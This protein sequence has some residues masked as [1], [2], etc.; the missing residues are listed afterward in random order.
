MK[1]D[2]LEEVGEK[3][4]I[5]YNMKLSNPTMSSKKYIIFLFRIVENG[6]GVKLKNVCIENI[7]SMVIFCSDDLYFYSCVIRGMW[8]F[9]T[10]TDLYPITNIPKIN[11]SCNF[12]FENFLSDILW[13]PL[14]I[15]ILPL[16]KHK[17]IEC[18]KSQGIHASEWLQGLNENSHSYF[19]NFKHRILLLCFYF[20]TFIIYFIKLCYVFHIDLCQVTE[21]LIVST[22]NELI[23]QLKFV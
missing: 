1:R 7:I 20:N 12:I 23:T 6:L 9:T 14:K 21:S 11:H 3:N 4:L 18:F 15:L 22:I 5:Q 8:Q 19:L 13:N 16:F 10:P 2:R 17:T